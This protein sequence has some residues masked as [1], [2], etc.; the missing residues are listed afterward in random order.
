[1]IFTENFKV[2]YYD[3][4]IKRYASPEK[5]LA[6]MGE[7]ATLH[8]DEIGLTIDDL[9]ENN[10]GWMLNRWKVKINDYPFARDTIKIETWASDFRKFY[11]NREFKILDNHNKELVKAS[12]IWIFLDMIKKRP[13]RVTD[14]II[15]GYGMEGDILF[16]EFYDFNN[17]FETEKGLEFRVRKSDIDYNNHVNNVKYFQ[18]MLESLPTYI[19]EEYKLKEFEILYKKE[20]G[21]GSLI[22][23]SYYVESNSDEIILLHKI[24][25]QGDIRA[26]GRTIW[27]K[28]ND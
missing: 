9:R 1:M 25:E 26:C 5:L 13:I 20:V 27:K 8:S 17:P 22:N 7:I 24:E 23:S 12:S 19:D 11:A 28:S 18:W 4:N 6:Y 21:L 3:T 14:N 16:S 2:P 10:Y 15:K